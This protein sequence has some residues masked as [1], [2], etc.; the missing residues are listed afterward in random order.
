M[1]SLLLCLSSSALSH[2][3]PGRESPHCC[4]YRFSTYSSEASLGMGC[5]AL[6]LWHLTF[7]SL[8]TTHG[9]GWREGFCSLFFVISY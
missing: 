8:N 5:T 4:C 3:V 7:H 9:A 1:L 6:Y 2:Q